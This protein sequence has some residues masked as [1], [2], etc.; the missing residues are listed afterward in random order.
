[1][2]RVVAAAVAAVGALAIGI[3]V[4]LGSG[5]AAPVRIAYV[6]GGAASAPQVWFASA[7]GLRRRRLGAGTGPLLSPDGST[8]AASSAATTGPALTLYSASGPSRRTFFNVADATA[9]AQ[10]WSPDSRYLAVVL[11]STDP[12]SDAASG[13]AVIDTSS[14]RVRMIAHGPTFGASF[15]PDGSDRIAY[16]SAGSTALAAAVNIHLAGADGT[17]YAQVTHDGRSLNPVWGPTAIAFDHERLRSGAEPVYQVWLM[18]PGGARRTEVTRLRVPP[19]LDGLVPLGFSSDGARLL[20]EYEGQDTSQA[21]TITIRT[22]RASRLA[23]AGHTVSAAAISRDGA[24]LLVDE[25]GF[26]NP[27]SAGIV[28]SLPFAGGR[29]RVLVLHASDPTWNR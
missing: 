22:D 16:A 2:R 29:P 11:S 21:W 28:E 12:A 17:K 8:V 24:L 4:S 15:A 13:L 20:A 23:L 7:A 19:A 1:M 18:A 3:G 25:G 10:S 26:L 27:P 5:V 6:T 9:V 14:D